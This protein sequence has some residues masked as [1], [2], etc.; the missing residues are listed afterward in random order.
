M[1]DALLLGIVGHAIGTAFFE[2]LSQ[3]GPWGRLVGFS[4]GLVYFACFDSRIASGQSIGK[5]L[6]KIRVIDSKGNAISFNKALLRSTIFLVP[7]FLYGLR[8]P[9]AQTPWIMSVAEFFVVYWIGGS[10]LYCIMFNRPARQG[11]HDL[12]VGTYV[13]STSETNPVRAGSIAITHWAILAILL[14]GATLGAETLN[15]TIEKRPPF[16]QLREDARLIEQL[17]CVQR[18]R[19]KDVH[20][21]ASINKS[22]K[23]DLILDIILQ[24]KPAS[25]SGFADDAAKMVLQHDQS[26][27]N[28]D[29][30]IVRLY[31]GYDIGI[32]QAWRHQ[33][34]TYTPAD[35][36]QQMRDS[37]SAPDRTR[38][39]RGVKP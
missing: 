29:R 5:R 6:L 33:E 4:I 7:C 28:C 30:L 3:L 15:D 17:S 24:S 9:E 23:G 39:D 18:A 34:F 26:A 12:A 19:V 8:T 27:E 20:R 13:T 22:K 11:L 16:P 1:V 32:A 25:P 35:W 10:T 31:Q 38:T 37:S 2:R 36:S 14:I 21:Y